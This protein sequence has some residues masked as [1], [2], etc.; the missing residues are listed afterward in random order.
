MYAI[1]MFSMTAPHSIECWLQVALT[2]HV[3]DSKESTDPAPSSSGSTSTST[4]TSSRNKSTYRHQQQAS[5][6]AMSKSLQQTAQQ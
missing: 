1:A 4:S 3:P 2:N 5:A 6:A